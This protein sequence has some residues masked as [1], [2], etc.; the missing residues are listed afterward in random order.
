MHFSFV[1]LVPLLA[2]LVAAAAWDLSS[3][4]IPNAIT[5]GIAVAGLGCQFWNSG[6]LAMAS[7]LGAALGSVAILYTFWVRGGLG[8]GDVKL[9]AAVA[10]WFGIGGLPMY[11]LTAALMGGVVA[12]ICFVRSTQTA[13][14]EIRQNLTLAVAQQVV[15][16]VPSGPTK[17]TGRISVPYGVA[18]ALGAV[19]TLWRG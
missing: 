9:A 17:Q 16:S 15:P 3:R 18:I 10:T 4:R 2:G 6:A 14:T 13:R 12:G 19:I 11:W 7:A 5:A 8:G 1:H